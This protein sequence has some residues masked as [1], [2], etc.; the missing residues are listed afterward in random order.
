MNPNENIISTPEK[1]DRQ[2]ASWD[3]QNA[4]RNYSTLVL[5]QIA[6]A[7]F[8]FASVWLA[9]RYLGTEGYGGIVA[10]IAASQV[11]QIFVNWTSISLARYGVEEFVETGKISKSF[12]GRSLILLPNTLIFLI[13][14]F[15]WF[16]LISSWLK[17]PPESIWYVLAHFLA[18]AFWIHIQYA[19]QGAKLPRLQGFLLAVERVLIFLLLLV[20]M[21]SGKIDYLS[22]IAAYIFPPILVALIGLFSM[23]KLISKRIEFDAGW[24]KKL[25]K[26]SVP[27][28]PFSLIGYLS[29]NYL[30]AI[31]ISQ[32]LTKSDLGIY[33]V[34]YQ[35][36]GIFMQ[37]PTLAG[38]LLLP[39]FVT[40]QADKQGEK[41]KFYMED[42]LPLV[43]F[44]GGLVGIFAAVFMQFVIPLIFGT[45]LN[46]AIIVFW[47][48]VSSSVIA[49]PG[50]IGYAPYSNSISATYI[51][52]IMA[53]VAA[54]VNFAANFW[55]IPLYGIKGSAWATVLAYTASNLVVMFIVSRRY[56]LE[57]KWTIPAVLPMLIGSIYASWTE[58]ILTAFVLAIFGAFVI[59]L[60]YRKPFLQSVRLLTAYW[61]R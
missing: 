52:T 44:T 6:S 46:G 9:T 18:Q 15:L 36:N 48:L 41:V 28:I 39:L 8:S 53:I 30:D 38:S 27:L 59:V 37:F 60:I 55:L 47:I 11:A 29:T 45:E 31:F 3:L 33:S 17:L 5:T 2:S 42:I 26:F 51:A 13:F 54:I 25:L 14:T 10:V 4:F 16:P 24:L 40:F 58:N 49:I 7:F 23:R 35:I 1:N 43:T 22:A 20:L 50:I 56:S 12:W 34:A 57:H 21:L 19:L 32:F 61:K